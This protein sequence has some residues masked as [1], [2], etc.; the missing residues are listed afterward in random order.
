MNDA[1]PT[2]AMMR[3]V[4]STIVDTIHLLAFLAVLSLLFILVVA[5]EE[6]AWSAFFL[7]SAAV[8]AATMLL[9]RMINWTLRGP[10]R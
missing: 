9:A 1:V 4:T 7:Q 5:R 2:Q 3:P 8:L 10:R 6:P